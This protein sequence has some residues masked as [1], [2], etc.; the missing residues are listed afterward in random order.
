MLT[1]LCDHPLLT[2]E[3]AKRNI[4]SEDSKLENSASLF[5]SRFLLRKILIEYTEDLKSSWETFV[6]DK[7]RFYPQPLP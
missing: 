7:L 2:S 4:F 6:M 1:F 3:S 5:L